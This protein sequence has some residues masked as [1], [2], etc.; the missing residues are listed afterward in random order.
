MAN[1]PGWVRRIT[2]CGLPASVADLVTYEPAEPEFCSSRV[3]ST[4]HQ[5]DQALEI[6]DRHQDRP[7][8]LFLNV[9]ATHVPHGHYLGESTDTAMSQQAALAYADEH[10]SRLI[11]SLTANRRWLIIMCADH[12]DAY[13]D[14]GFHGRGIAHPMVMNV[15]YA[16]MVR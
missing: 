7:L 4:S 16:A 13:G 15:P 2:P 14:D 10:L 8:F 5:V 1:G 3:D 11:T 9:S 12:G 6:A